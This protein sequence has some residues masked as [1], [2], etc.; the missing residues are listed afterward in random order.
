MACCQFCNVAGNRYLEQAL[1]TGVIFDGRTPDELVAMRLPTVLKTRDS[2]RRYWEET[3]ART[4][5]GAD[6]S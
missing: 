1:A 2:Y 6:Q 3:V 5:P 4:V